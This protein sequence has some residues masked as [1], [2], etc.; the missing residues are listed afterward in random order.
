MSTVPASHEVAALSVVS[1][2]AA[3]DTCST[4][5]ETSTTPAAA[6]AILILFM[7]PLPVVRHC[8]TGWNPGVGPSSGGRHRHL[9]RLPGQVGAMPPPHN[10]SPRPNRLATHFSQPHSFTPPQR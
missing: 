7:F 10:H 3:D 6:P 1:V 8:T 9:E 2:N 5:P 4:I